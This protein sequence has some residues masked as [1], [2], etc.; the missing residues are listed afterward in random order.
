[1]L[2]QKIAVLRKHNLTDN[3]IQEVMEV[4]PETLKS[5]SD[6]ASF[7]PHIVEV[8]WDD[9]FHFLCEHPEQ[10]TITFRLWKVSQAHPQ[11]VELGS[12]EVNVALCLKEGADCFGIVRTLRMAPSG[13]RLKVRWQVRWMGACTTAYRPSIYP[14]FIQE[15]DEDEKEEEEDTLAEPEAELEEGP[16]S[17]ESSLEEHAS[18]LVPP[19]DILGSA[20]KPRKKKKREKTKKAMVPGE[21]REYRNHKQYE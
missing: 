14:P 11:Q 16:K 10:A 2:Q 1:V 6:D 19:K 13:I 7:K 4:H 20:A 18:D 8:R 9:L 5:L 15:E 17:R 12:A 3:E 21:E